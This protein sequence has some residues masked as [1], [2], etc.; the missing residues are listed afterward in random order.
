MPKIHGPFLVT[1]NGTL[2]GN[3]GPLAPRL[4][5]IDM[6][7]LRFKDDTAPVGGYTNRDGTAVFLMHQ[8]GKTYGYGWPTLRQARDHDMPIREITVAQ[9]Q[10]EKKAAEEAMAMEENPLFGMF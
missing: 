4:R 1:P 2:D 6:P 8:D 10:A 5:N 9:I 7:A 3:Y